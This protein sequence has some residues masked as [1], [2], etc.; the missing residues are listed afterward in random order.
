MKKVIKIK[1][2]DGNITVLTKE[3]AAKDHLAAQQK[4]KAQTFRDRTKYTRK[5]K[6]KNRSDEQEV[7]MYTLYM[8]VRDALYKYLVVEHYTDTNETKYYLKVL[9][10]TNTLI[11]TY[12]SQDDY[13]DIKGLFN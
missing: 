9:T 10:H 3:I 7:C 1:D 13:E 12:I 11:E 6:H 5:L 2:F 4:Y 8:L